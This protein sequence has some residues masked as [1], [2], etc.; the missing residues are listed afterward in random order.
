MIKRIFE[1]KA[2]KKRVFVWMGC[3]EERDVQS[4]YKLFFFFLSFIL[5]SGIVGVNEI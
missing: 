1:L 4:V 3:A 5:Q 2:K